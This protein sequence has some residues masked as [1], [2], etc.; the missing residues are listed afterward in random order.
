MKNKLYLL[1]ILSACLSVVKAQTV[2]TLLYERFETGG[3][4]FQLNTTDL[5]GASGTAGS[6][7]WVINNIYAGGSGQ[8]T[9]LGFPFT[10]TIPATAQQPA[11][12]T[13]G[14]TTNYLHI[15]SDAAQASGIQNNNFI[16]ADGIC[17]L[18]ES[19]FARMAQDV[20]TTA[21]D[22]VTVSFLWMCGGGTN[23]YG[24][25]HY[26]INQGVSWNPVTTPVSQY[27]NQSGW[28]QQSITLPA[29]AGQQNLR[30]GFRFVNQNSNAANDPGF[31]IDE[32]MIVGKVN[33]APP[34]AAFS[35]SDS[36][37]CQGDCVD[38]TDLSTGNP[39]SWFWVF[40]GATTSFSTQQNPSQV[41]YLNPG[42]FDVTL[43]VTNSSGNDTLTVTTITVNTN[44]AT[45][46]ITFSGDTLIAT[47]GYASYQWLL[48]NAIIPGADSSVYVTQTNGSYSVI[49]TDSNGCSAES[50]TLNYST[51][52]AWIDGN[53]GIL[54]S[55]NPAVDYLTV[56]S[57]DRIDV[58]EITDITGKT[59]LQ[60][61][62]AGENR[63]RIDVSSLS[64][65]MYFLIARGRGGSVT[66]R[67]IKW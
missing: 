63:F 3:T 66:E 56:E 33:G 37:L 15:L 51:G 54:V 4:S 19:N 23:I 29:F 60:Q 16:A 5:G 8:L 44:P 28:V 42:T 43:I 39:T 32:F 55:P 52:V 12:Q 24:E 57:F 41:C 67:L 17:T 45:P 9:C 27:K 35:V 14:V 30:F 49:V 22:S 38:F 61:S 31:G 25:L 65:G 13:G 7:A 2:D 53:E 26:S 59:V 46:Q 64:K 10:F 18:D 48:N 1:L 11:A 58:I 40:Q 6:N 47:P 34:V 36:T 20:N 50:D 62:A 21:F